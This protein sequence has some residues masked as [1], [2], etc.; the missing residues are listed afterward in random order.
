MNR[1]I[2][3]PGTLHSLLGRM[4]HRHRGKTIQSNKQTDKQTNH[5]TAAI[6]WQVMKGRETTAAI[7]APLSQEGRG[8]SGQGRGGYRLTATTCEWSRQTTE[9]D[10]QRAIP[11]LSFAASALPKK[12]GMVERDTRR[13]GDEVEGETRAGVTVMRNTNQKKVPRN[14]GEMNQTAKNR[15][16]GSSERDKRNR[17]R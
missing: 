15:T 5:Q 9:N 14:T 16:S 11:H 4:T 10:D 2:A 6:D 7:R 12:N 13:R 8:G 1:A 17:Q 3:V